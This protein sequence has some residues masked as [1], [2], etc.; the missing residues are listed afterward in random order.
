MDVAHITTQE[1]QRDFYPGERVILHLGEDRLTGYIREKTKFPEL[2]AHDNTQERKAF[3]RYFCYLDDRQ[4]EEALVDEEHIQRERKIFTK[5]R[6]RSFLKNSVTREAWAGAPWLVKPRLAEDYR[7]NTLIPECLTH[8]YQSK[9]RKNSNAYS[10]KGEYEG[11]ILN[12]YGPHHGLPVLKPK[13]NKAKNGQDELRIQSERWAEYQRA[14]ASNPDFG[15]VGPHGQT[16]PFNGFYSGPPPPGYQIVNGYKP[17]AAKGQARLVPPPPPKYPIEDLEIPPVH[18]GTHRPP[19]KFLSHDTPS[20]DR[21]S[22][23]A[24]SGIDMRSVGPLLETWDTL[25]V[26]CE[27]FQLDSFTFDDFVEALRFSSADVQCELLVEIHCAVLK[28]LVNDIND[29]NGMIQVTLPN[30]I[31]SEEELVQNGIAQATP[32]PE[33]ETKPPA[34]STRSS[35]VKSEAQELKSATNSDQASSADTKIHRAAEMDRS[36]KGFDWKIR[37][38]KRDFADQRWV[39]IIV[40]LIN[41]LSGDPRLTQV[42]NDILKHLAPIDEDPTPATAALQYQTLD[43][44][45]RIKILQIICMKSV[46]TPA[47]RRY[48]EDC[49]AQMTEHRKDKNE[50]QRQRKAA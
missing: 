31:E 24:D 15:Q 50:I 42:C 46:E 29:K 22:E 25:N 18:D 43:I 48:M 35:L 33:P 38:R 21:V 37:L 9:Q 41:Q 20:V 11:P 40:G 2:R 19:L 27:V 3:A 36:T 10:K 49:S 45:L 23:G 28:K 26:Y 8:Q 7:I 5:Q 14:S 34:R 6:L 12:F 44:N 16:M 30:Q 47:I 1:F 13:G 4:G 39:V 32:T 17:I